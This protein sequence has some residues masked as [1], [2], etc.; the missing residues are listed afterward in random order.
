[1]LN[2]CPPLALLS[3]RLG[4]GQPAEIREYLVMSHWHLGV[5]EMAKQLIYV[6]QPTEFNLLQGEIFDG[7]S[8]QKYMLKNLVALGD[9]NWT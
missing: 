7:E 9:K 3:G 1:M 8:C 5:T 2:A 4:L 6:R